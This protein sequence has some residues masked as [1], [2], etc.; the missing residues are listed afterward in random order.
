MARSPRILNPTLN[1]ASHASKID[2]LI[3]NFA[4]HASKID[5]L[6]SKCASHV[7]KID[8]WRSK[9]NEITF[10]RH[11]ALLAHDMNLELAVKMYFLNESMPP[12]ASIQQLATSSQQ[13]AVSSKKQGASNQQQAASS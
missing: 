13:L 12:V 9:L 3:L 5:V 2:V 7:S 1:F 6:I 11:F 4:S 8:V 10:G